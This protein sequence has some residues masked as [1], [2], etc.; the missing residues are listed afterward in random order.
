M[1]EM[2]LSSRHRIRNSSTGGANHHPRAPARR[3]LA[4]IWLT[5]ESLNQESRIMVHGPYFRTSYDIS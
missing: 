2:T 5:L 1:N 4:D 3:D